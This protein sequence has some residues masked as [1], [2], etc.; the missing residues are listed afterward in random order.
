MTPVDA[1]SP[2]SKATECYCNDILFMCGG[3]PIK[4]FARTGDA[5]RIERIGDA[6]LYLWQRLANTVVS[7]YIKHIIL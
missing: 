7:D 2:T 1:A 6:F 4:Y 3:L 5:C